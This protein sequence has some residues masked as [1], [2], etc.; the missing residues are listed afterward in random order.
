MNDTVITTSTTVQNGAPKR[1][2]AAADSPS[3]PSDIASRTADVEAE[4]KRRAILN[5][6]KR[7]SGQLNAVIS[8]VENGR[9]CADT[10][11]QLSAASKALDRVG[12]LIIATSMRECIGNASTNAPQPTIDELEKLFL[13]LA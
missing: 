3:T 9:S 10:I 12:F 1:A 5:R 13:T 2:D 11:T 7:A 4:R 8:S 6:L